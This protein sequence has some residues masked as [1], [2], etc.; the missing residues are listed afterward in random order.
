MEFISVSVFHLDATRF[1]TAFI[2]MAIY[3]LG[4]QPYN[5][6]VKIY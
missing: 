4:R 3:M 2:V 5:K 6:S 1:L